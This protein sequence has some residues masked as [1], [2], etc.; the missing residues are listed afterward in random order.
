MISVF[1]VFFIFPV[2][3]ALTENLESPKIQPFVIPTNLKPGDK[4]SLTCSSIKGQPPFTIKW[5]KNGESFNTKSNSKIKL[6][7]NEHISTLYFESINS[8]D[9]GNY[10]CEMSNKHGQD[11]YTAALNIQAPPEW[12]WVPKDVTALEGESAVL[13]CQARGSPVPAVTW[14]K[15][16]GVHHNSSVL[17]FSPV[18]R[19]HGGK[20]RCTADNGLGPPIYHTVSLTVH[21]EWRIPTISLQ[22]KTYF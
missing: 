22:Y 21:C 7:S 6:V 2:C 10:T 18:E 13:K 8:S 12:V 5:L 17:N 4:V 9:G 1:S 14:T 3:L 16:E 15:M 11:S 20:Y 19:T